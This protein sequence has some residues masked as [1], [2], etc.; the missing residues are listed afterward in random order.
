M[1]LACLESAKA[2]KVLFCVSMQLKLRIYKS[3]VDTE[4]KNLNEPQ[5][6]QYFNSF[7]TQLTVK[8]NINVKN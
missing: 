7:Y 4:S 5:G 2:I 8:G 3:S 6:M 1:I